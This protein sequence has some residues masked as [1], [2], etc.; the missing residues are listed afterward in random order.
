MLLEPQVRFLLRGS[1]LLICLLTLWWFVL[2]GPMLYLLKGATSVFVSIEEN[3]SGAWTLRV[4]F[5]KTLPPTPQQ[6]V[7]RQ[8]RSISIDM[9]R[10]DVTMFIFSLPVYW[11]IILAAPSMRRNVLPLVLGTLVMSAA[12]IAL[13]LGYVEITALSAASQLTST[14]H[15]A[16]W[17]RQVEFYLIVNVLPYVV[18]F[19]VALSLHRVLRNEVFPRGAPMTQ[20][21][22]W[23]RWCETSNP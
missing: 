22:R 12:E 4:P 21:P 16:E 15:I 1:A 5:V 17:V 19:I 9:T 7:A 18:P 23:P 2:L 11:A 8:I 6:S 10:S 14:G 3:S 20:L 13:L